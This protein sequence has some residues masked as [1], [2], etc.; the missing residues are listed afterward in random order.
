MP[1]T[2]WREGAPKTL[3]L[4][5]DRSARCDRPLDRAVQL[6][7]DWNAR[8][9]VLHVI[10]ELPRA[11]DAG[12]L[13][14]QLKSKL[15]NEMPNR[16][17][18]QVEV[19]IGAVSD[20]VLATAR[21][22]AAD[23]IITGVARY[24]ELGD[25]VLGTT[26]DR[27]VRASD[28]PVLVVKDRPRTGYTKLLLPTDYSDCSARAFEVLPAFPRADATL[29]HAYH[30]P[31]EG[32]ISRESNEAEFREMD[33]AAC[34]AFLGRLAP[35]LRERIGV[36][37]RYGETCQVLTRAIHDN[38]FDL[39]VLGTHGQ[40]GLGRALIGSTAEALLGCLPCDV[41]M[42]PVRAQP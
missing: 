32:F 13:V 3:L 30:V 26:V 34:A 17:P 22:V 28:V 5:T 18:F 37:N 4:A 33:A 11:A 6:A 8:L 20:A 29:M 41:L 36:S 21:D 35:A 19:R 24:N 16:A 25:Y 12:S 42:V 10:E 39:A 9:V 2:N 40:G 31:Y 38:G 14:S 7:H 1:L 15:F 23:L 27:L